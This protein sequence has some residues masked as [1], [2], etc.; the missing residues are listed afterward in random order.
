M[1]HLGFRCIIPGA[2]W[3]NKADASKTP[4]AK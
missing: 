2:A 3:V 1:Q 4:A